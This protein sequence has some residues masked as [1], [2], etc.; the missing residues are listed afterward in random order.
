[1]AEA[2]GYPLNQIKSCGQFKRT[3]MLILEAWEAIYR[4]MVTSFIENTHNE[5]PTTDLQEKVC[6]TLKWVNLKGNF[7]TISLNLSH[8][9]RKCHQQM[10]C[11]WRFWVQFVFQDAMAY[12]CIT[13]P[14]SERW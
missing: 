14:C 5:H 2:A 10:T 9:S 12:M 7:S 13:F 1:M 3:H 11:T 4:A 8:S 6:Q